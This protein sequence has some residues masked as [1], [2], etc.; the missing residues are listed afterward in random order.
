MSAVALSPDAPA[1]R[2]CH[3]VKWPDYEGFGFNLHSEKSK[4]G[5]YLG[6][7][8]EGSPAQL[9]GLREGDRIVEVNGINISNENHKQVVERIK[10]VPNETKLLVVDP[11]ADAWYKEHKIIVKN[12][13][14]TVKQCR[15]PVPRP[16]KVSAVCRPSLLECISTSFSATALSAVFSEPFLLLL[17]G[18]HDTIRYGGRRCSGLTSQSGPRSEP[19]GAARSERDLCPAAAGGVVFVYVA[20]ACAQHWP[21]P[22]ELLL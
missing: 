10:A 6:K 21:S 5:Q 3:V 7:I 22:R 16:G 17:R 4:P 14:P 12:S 11:L 9:A 18:C 19:V 2:L 8:D 15:N 1:I 20:Q 13:L